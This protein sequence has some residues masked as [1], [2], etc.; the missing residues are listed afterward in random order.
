MTLSDDIRPVLYRARKKTPRQRVLAVLCAVK[1]NQPATREWLRRYAADDVRSFASDATKW[2]RAVDDASTYLSMSLLAVRRDT[3]RRIISHSLRD[4]WAMRPSNDDPNVLVTVRLAPSRARKAR[5]IAAVVGARL[6]ADPRGWDTTI[7]NLEDLAV[8]LHITPKTAAAWLKIAEAEGVISLRGKTRNGEHRVAL[9]SWPRSHKPTSV[10][11]AA[12]ASILDGDPDIVARW[13]L[14]AA[15]S[16]WHYDDEL[17]P[18]AWQASVLW[19]A[20]LKKPRGQMRE[21][22][23]LLS[24]PLDLDL[25]LDA[26]Q[27]AA[28]AAV[29]RDDARAAYADRQIAR[30]AEKDAVRS[31]LASWG[32]TP[33]A[34]PKGDDGA[35]ER[36]RLLGEFVTRARTEMNR[37]PEPSALLLETIARNLRAHFP[38]P[39]DAESAIDFIRKDFF[40]EQ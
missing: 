20:G 4:F 24:D 11:K 35:A 22:L 13:V 26:V 23:A 10:E 1:D 36:M 34:W 18:A 9:R 30:K 27:R 3:A 8:T 33:E 39:A 38:D 6:L 14:S 7:L 17:T 15:H 31:T 5:I 2:T 32:W 25:R 16:A 40:D 12:S 21:R 29:V 37:I 28:D 19:S